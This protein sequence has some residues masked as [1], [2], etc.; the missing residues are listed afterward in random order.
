MYFVQGEGISNIARLTFSLPLCHGNQHTAE[1][2]CTIHLLIA[3]G[4][5]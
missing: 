5:S 2:G 1:R 3:A 4:T